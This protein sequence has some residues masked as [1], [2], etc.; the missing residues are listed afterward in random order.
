MSRISP[1]VIFLGRAIISATIGMMAS[2]SNAGT[3][4]RKFIPKGKC[5]TGLFELG[6]A[7]WHET[8]FRTLV[9]AL[10]EMA[11]SA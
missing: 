9:A 6:E 5:V 1:K 7:S 4:Y 8:A 11:R 2:G 3:E 10:A